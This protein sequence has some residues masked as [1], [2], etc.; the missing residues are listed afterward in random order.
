MDFPYD[1]FGLRPP[2]RSPE[3]WGH[4]ER[5]FRTLRGLQL[6]IGPAPGAAAIGHSDVI[7]ADV[8]VRPR[9]GL[10]LFGC[11]RSHEPSTGAAR[12][13]AG[14]TLALGTGTTGAATFRKP[15]GE[16][17]PERASYNSDGW[18]TD[19]DDDLGFHADL[20]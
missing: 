5:F 14:R 7:G 17:E 6:L 11:F 19:E 10:N 18:S 20:R 1:R 13:N 2:G 15:L 3:Q 9:K 4:F 16:P 12:T 8:T